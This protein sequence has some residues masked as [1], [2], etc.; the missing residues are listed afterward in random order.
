MKSYVKLVNFEL[1]R[2]IKIYLVLAGITIIS[3]LSGT[4]FMANGYMGSFNEAIYN[5][6]VSI[7]QFLERY[8]QIS[9]I[10]L[11][12][13]PWFNLPILFAAA[14]LVFY[15]FFI[16]YRDW[17][18]KN[19][20]IYRLLMLPTA[21]LNIYLSK[22]TAIFLMVL[23]LVALQVIL[24]Q[25][26]GSILKW[27]VPA[28]LRVDFPLMTLIASTLGNLHIGVLIPTSF[29]QFLIHYGIGFLAVFIVFTAIL[30][31]RSF[32]FIGILYGI[33]Y[34]LF[35]VVVFTLPMLVI[36]IMQKEYLYPMELF[37]VEV[38]LWVLVTAMSIW[39]SNYL[40]NK[41]ITV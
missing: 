12:S 2:F 30:F 29:T 14:A 28:N 21:R 36:G 3:Q 1:G 4:V 16:W 41:K 22:A 33:L 31:E 20:F 24:F 6:G 18:G 17:F 9:L 32:R 35:A 8:G 34:A 23:G 27:L 11:L 39:V 38:I 37:I 19:T 13:I 15:C 5:D 26:S 7:E 25:L 10:N 40:L